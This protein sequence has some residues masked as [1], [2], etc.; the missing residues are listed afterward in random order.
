MRFV[1]RGGCARQ[2]ELCV[3]AHLSSANDTSSCKQ[4][5]LDAIS[6]F[7]GIKDKSRGLYDEIWFMR[8]SSVPIGSEKMAGFIEKKIQ[9]QIFFQVC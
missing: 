6:D 1:S 2:I 9:I 8:K 7:D 3:A 5:A 4:S